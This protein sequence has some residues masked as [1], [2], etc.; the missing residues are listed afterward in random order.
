VPDPT[1]SLPV[2]AQSPLLCRPT[3]PRI[4][5]QAPICTSDPKQ[6]P[7]NRDQSHL[8]S[9]PILNRNTAS[10]PPPIS[11]ILKHRN[12][13][14]R[15]KNQA[16]SS[17]EPDPILN[18][19]KVEVPSPKCLI[20]KDGKLPNSNKST[21]FSRYRPRTAGRPSGTY[22]MWTS[23]RTQPM[24]EGLLAN[25]NAAQNQRIFQSMHP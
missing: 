9:P 13:P 16:Y 23:N 17:G 8:T 10:I 3:G 12:H 24:R 4:P 20:T 21:F 14:Y 25:P 5:P 1:T 11:L 2:L 7:S 15:G 6:A 22:L 19:N 18:S